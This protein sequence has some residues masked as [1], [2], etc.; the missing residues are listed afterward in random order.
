MPIRDRLRSLS[1]MLGSQSLPGRLAR[2]AADVADDLLGP[3]TTRTPPPAP[4]PKPREP[5]PVFLYVE[6]DSPG[7]EKMEALLRERGIAYKLFSIDGDEATQAFV[8]RF[9]KQG[10]PLLFIGGD[11]VGGLEELERLSE[12]ELRRRVF[13]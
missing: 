12:E 5:A 13:G 4:P 2:R 9:R 11:P 8:A 3:G 1:S 7:R 10:A 6:W